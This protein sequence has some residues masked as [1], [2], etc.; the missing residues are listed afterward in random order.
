MKKLILSFF[1]LI[2]SFCFIL[3]GNSLSALPGAFGQM[4]REAYEKIE[5]MKISDARKRLLKEKVS[6]ELE[7]AA[8]QHQYA[9]GI[10]KRTKAYI[11]AGGL[12]TE[13]V[14]GVVNSSSGVLGKVDDAG[15]I[16]DTI[17]QIK[18]IQGNPYL[19]DDAKRATKALATVG[20]ILQ[21][22]GDIVPV[23]LVSDMV[24]AYGELSQGMASVTEGVARKRLEQNQGYI[25]NIRSGTPEDK[26]LKELKDK[27]QIPDNLQKDMELQEM[28][29]PL[30]NVKFEGEGDKHFLKVGDTYHEIKDINELKRLVGDWRITHNQE[31]PDPATLK[32][33]L[34]GGVVKD[35]GMKLDKTWVS[36]LA[37]LKVQ[38]TMDENIIKKALGGFEYNQI[39]DDTEKL[40]RA[41]DELNKMRA[42]L[43]KRGIVYDDATLTAL[44]RLKLNGDTETVN[45]MLENLSKPPKIETQ[46]DNILEAPGDKGM[47]KSGKAEQNPPA[48]K[49]PGGLPTNYFGKML[50]NEGMGD[51]SKES[52]PGF[53]PGMNNKG[54]SIEMPETE[55]PSPGY[56]KKGG[57]DNAS[58]NGPGIIAGTPA[59]RGGSGNRR[60]DFNERLYYAKIDAKEFLKDVKIKLKME[61]RDLQEYYLWNKQ[62]LINER[63]IDLKDENYLASIPSTLS[64]LVERLTSGYSKKEEYP[65]YTIYHIDLPDGMKKEIVVKNQSLVSNLYLGMFQYEMEENGIPPVTGLTI[66]EY[67]KQGNLVYVEQYS[68]KEK[69]DYGRLSDLL[70][71]QQR[72]TDYRNGFMDEKNT[73]A[74]EEPEGKIKELYERHRREIIKE[75]KEQEQDLENYYSS[76]INRLDTLEEKLSQINDV[77]SDLESF[78][79]GKT[80]LDQ[81]K[82]AF[83]EMMKTF[84]GVQSELDKLNRSYWGN[85]QDDLWRLNL[86]IEGASELIEEDIKQKKELGFLPGENIPSPMDSQMDIQQQNLGSDISTPEASAQRGQQP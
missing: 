54:P 26:L 4:E 25:D 48:E 20:A 14:K 63:D 72:V 10:I 51:N 1:F 28:G 56:A 57:P 41:R 60:K 27:N 79:S 19:S 64:S 46:S 22:V 34:D 44:T 16:A 12:A 2:L 40:K 59:H 3:S 35:K 75:Y 77:L 70:Y 37:D 73:V 49:S 84:S 74:L 17:S 86:S 7:K 81:L 50:N 61:R 66:R 85:V 21:K 13:K 8:R 24:S 38:Q 29:I 9:M 80:P 31:S 39:A 6:R 15:L 78:S 83:D 52:T 69:E 11:D 53:S 18:G 55:S 62:R 67:N 5:K 36:D 32:T 76:Q 47:D 30:I 42:E 58:T 33:L 43:E 65:G 23:P 68:I 45:R 71:I 82:I